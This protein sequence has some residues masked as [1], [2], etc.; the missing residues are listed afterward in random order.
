MPVALIFVL[1]CCI[2]L[3]TIVIFAADQAAACAGDRRVPEKVL[4]WLA[5]LGGSP[6]AFWA[7]QRYR[8]KTRKQPFSSRLEVI[9]MLQAGILLGLGI[10]FAPF[11]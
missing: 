6:G 10:T 3:M 4:L 1:L 8:H 7:R 9:A 11:T 5:A 2:N